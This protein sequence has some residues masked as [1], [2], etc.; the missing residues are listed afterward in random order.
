MAHSLYEKPPGDYAADITECDYRGIFEVRHEGVQVAPYAHYR[1]SG[2][3]AYGKEASAG[4]CRKGYEKPLVKA[5]RRV[6]LQ[7][8][9][10]DRDVVDHCRDGANGYVRVCR[11][12]PAEQD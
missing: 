5:H 7:H 3:R 12:T 9:V 11:P 10:H 4:A 2:G 1:H 8:G 6:H